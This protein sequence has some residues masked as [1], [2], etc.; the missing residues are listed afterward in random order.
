MNQNDEKPDPM[1]RGDGDDGY[2]DM[3]PGIRRRTLVHGERAL[4]AAFRLEAGSRI[5]EHSH[6]EEQTGYLVSGAM[7]FYI[8]GETHSARPGDS[9]SIPGGVKHAVDVREDSLA[10]EAFSPVRK[11]YL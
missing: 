2:V 4:L 6:P 10:I 11:D 5:P 8:G 9:W 7:T 3:A 1:F